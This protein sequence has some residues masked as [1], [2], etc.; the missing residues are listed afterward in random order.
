MAWSYFLSAHIDAAHKMFKKA[1]LLVVMLFACFRSEN[2]NETDKDD[3][4]KENH[5]NNAPA[6]QFPTI[7]TRRNSVKKSNHILMLTILE[8]D[9]L[10][11]LF[12]QLPVV[13][14]RS[15]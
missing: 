8:T 1:K 3:N 2:E 10:I 9:P 12:S 11:Y 7:H 4:Q 14:C 15:E 13:G 6:D 5:D